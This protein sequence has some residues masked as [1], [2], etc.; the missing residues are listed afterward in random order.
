MLTW[1]DIIVLDI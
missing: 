1:T